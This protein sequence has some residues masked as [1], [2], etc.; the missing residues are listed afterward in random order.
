MWKSILAFA[1]GVISVFGYAPWG[2]F[3]LPVLALAVL[4]W[5]LR[6]AMTAREAMRLGFAFGL[7]LFSFGVSWVH[8]SLNQFGGLPLPLAWLAVVLFAVFL[9]LFPALALGLAVR[10]F[11]P[12]ARSLALPAFWVLLEGVRGTVLTGFPW[13]ALGYSQV[14]DSPLAGYAPVLGVYGVS[15]LAA[16][17]ASLVQRWRGVLWL[18]L[19]GVA[20]AGLKTVHWTQPVGEP[21]RVSLLQGNVAQDMKFHPEHR[22]QTLRNY[23]LM[24][25]EAEGELKILPETALPLLLSEVPPS[26]LRAL[27][28][29]GTV[30]VGVPE[31]ADG[32]YYNSLIWLD[33]AQQGNWL[34]YRKRHLVPFGEFTPPGFGW[35]ASALHIPF[36]DFGRGA[37]VQ[38]PF[39]V[40][41]QRVAANICY[42]DVFGE[43]LI[44]AAREATLMVNVS[45]DAWFG[46][47]AAPWQHLQI[48]QMRALET[49][50]WQMRAN[51]TGITAV[52][53]AQG[54]VVKQLPPFQLGV[55]ETVAE[56]RNGL[57]PYLRW[58]NVPV[59][60]LAGLLLL[61]AWV[62]SRPSYRHKTR[63]WS[64]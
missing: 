51:N 12:A 24:A 2:W 28:Q 62:Q 38:P 14:P 15:L 1:L 34:R 53:D 33:P 49:G 9:A 54:A 46:P 43:E 17:S 58:G 55:L 39:V 27:G 59:W 50:R 25:R 64:D 7:G 44:A 3:V 16:L 42:E 57:T 37:A 11:R 41:G 23:L 4:F 61:W 36:S 60:L 48:A 63:K 35:L 40:A 56:G 18:V 6:D 52:L 21:L 20:G 30:L 22:R 19:I 5:M 47:S 10:L 29:T 8:V 26:Y 13:L 31:A 32:A 45:N